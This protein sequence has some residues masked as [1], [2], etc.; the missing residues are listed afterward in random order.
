M[1]RDV[2]AFL[3]TALVLFGAQGLIALIHT[4]SFLSQGMGAATIAMTIGVC[5]WC[6]LSVTISV[7]VVQGA[8]C[9]MR[10][11]PGAHPW[12]LVSLLL[13]P[14]I[15]AAP[16]ALPFSFIPLNL[17]MFIRMSGGIGVGVNG[18]GIALLLWYLTRI[19]THV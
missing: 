15:F 10:Q 7:C 9:V 13:S 19:R 16:D 5:A 14:L 8:Y 3:L 18:I 17:H 11:V 12:L 2:A 4:V 6:A 1:R